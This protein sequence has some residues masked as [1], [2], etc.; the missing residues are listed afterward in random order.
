MGAIG[1]SGVSIEEALPLDGSQAL[2]DT[3]NIDQNSNSSSIVIDSEATSANVINITTPTT[4]TGRVFN[5]ADADSLT[6]GSIVRFSSNSASASSR[7]L[8]VVTNFNASATSATVANFR[9]DAANQVMI[10]DQNAASSFIDYQGTA[11]ANATDP[12]S[13]LT[14]SGATTHHLQIEINGVQAWVAASTT[15]PS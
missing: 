9:Q 1:G 7:N 12:I 6:T 10:L 11:A 14:T 8:V 3:L 5:C 15:D 13:T 4:T 2:T